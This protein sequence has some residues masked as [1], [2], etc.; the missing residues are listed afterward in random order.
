MAYVKHQANRGKWLEDAISIC[1]M[2]YENKGIALIRKVPTDVNF[3]TRTGRA[4]YKAKGMVD[5]VG[6]AKGKMIAFDAKNTNAESIPFNNIKD[7]QEEY[8]LKVDELGGQ[9]FFLIYFAK[10]REL[11]RLD[12]KEYMDIKES[13]DR[14]SIPYSYFRDMKMSVQ[15][16]ED[17]AFDYLG[18]YTMEIQ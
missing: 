17:I 15:G 13:L 4:F 8:L 10:Y 14:K 7:H 5:F 3:N 9:A 6:I 2:H 18:V 1:N 11:Y 12:I 16:Y